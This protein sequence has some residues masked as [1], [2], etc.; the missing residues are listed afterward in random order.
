MLMMLLLLMGV[1]MAES[2]RKRQRTG[3][4][5]TGSPSSI[6]E[7]APLLQRTPAGGGASGG[8]AASSAAAAAAPSRATQGS[9]VACSGTLA[10][11]ATS[12][13]RCAGCE[14]PLHVFCGRAVGGGGLDDEDQPRLCAECDADVGKAPSTHDWSRD[15]LCEC[16]APDHSADRF[17]GEC[18]RL[19]RR[20]LALGHNSV[21]GAM[22]REDPTG[23]SLA[24]LEQCLAIPAQEHERQNRRGD[25]DDGGTD[26]TRRIHEAR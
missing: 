21:C 19:P 3:A 6:S 17:C 2:R 9:C 22:Q 4:A 11:T 8:G 16:E 24:T 26:A 10:L 5:G 20:A 18:G 12:R 1:A 25:D 14:A 7:R 13:C 15:C 23:D